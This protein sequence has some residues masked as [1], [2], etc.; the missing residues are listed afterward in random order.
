MGDLMTSSPAE[1]AARFDTECQFIWHLMPHTT[2]SS[3]RCTT[4]SRG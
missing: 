1:F 4:G 2:P 3:R